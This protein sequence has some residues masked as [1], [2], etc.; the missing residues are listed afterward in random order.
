MFLTLVSKRILKNELS[1]PSFQVVVWFQVP[2]SSCLPQMPFDLPTL[3]KPAHGDSK[4]D[5][6]YSPVGGGPVCPSIE[7]ISHPRQPDAQ[8]VHSLLLTT[9][10]LN[11]LKVQ[12]YYTSLLWIFAMSPIHFSWCLY[13]TSDRFIHMF[14]VLARL[15]GQLRRTQVTI[16][17]LCP[18]Q[19]L[20]Q[21]RSI[22]LLC[23]ISV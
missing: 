18:Y 23:K 6:S 13:N 4:Q 17:E 1:C 2:P 22:M 5:D 14:P 19:S 7:S 11:G 21:Q 20:F 3:G 16:V 15:P 10:Q 9:P 8:S 12:S